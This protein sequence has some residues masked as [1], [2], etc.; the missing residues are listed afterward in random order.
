MNKDKLMASISMPKRIDPTSPRREL[1]IHEEDEKII[2][3]A[4]ET[5]D[6]SSL[7]TED[8]YAVFSDWQTKK[9]L[10]SKRIFV[11]TS[12][13]V[14]AAAWIGID[15]TELSFFGLKVA[16]GSPERFIIFVLIS[17][18]ASGVFYEFSRRID[19]SVRNARIKNVSSDLKDLVGPIES[20]DGAMDRNDIRDF[21]DL[22][23]DFRSS[24]SASKHDAI[25]VYRAVKFYKNN[26][27]RA[28]VGLSIVTLSEHI[29]VYSIAAIALISLTKQLVQ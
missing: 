15:Y 20:I 25:D 10:T 7:K 21:V 5:L 8:L 16:N 6:R 17:I 24:L 29:I 13:L 19:A 22:Y 9:T 26:L 2:G 3:E 1:D 14:S 28:G 27:S 18:L 4:I 12:I 11:S 23:Y